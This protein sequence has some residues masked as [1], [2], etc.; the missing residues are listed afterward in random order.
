VRLLLALQS[1]PASP[2]IVK[3]TEP[4]DTRMRDLVIGVLKLAGTLALSALVIG[5]VAA[6]LVYWF[7]SKQD[8]DRTDLRL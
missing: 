3:I 5:L 6:G 4:P 7:R 1:T 2:I 8:N